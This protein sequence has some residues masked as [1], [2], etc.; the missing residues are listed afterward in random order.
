M[1]T[2]I[3]L[4]ACAALA[5]CA[6]TTFVTRADAPSHYQPGRIAPPDGPGLGITVDRAA[7]GPPDVTLD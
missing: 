1:K 4:T 7:L 3:T 5:A 6:E 2:V